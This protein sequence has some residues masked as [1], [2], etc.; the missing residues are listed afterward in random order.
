MGGGHFQ[1][2]VSGFLGSRLVMNYLNLTSCMLDILWA[3]LQ[4]AASSEE[5]EVL[6][7]LP[8]KGISQPFLESTLGVKMATSKTLCQYVL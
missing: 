5:A 6:H 3:V 8:Y 2:V 7:I 1:S 4:S